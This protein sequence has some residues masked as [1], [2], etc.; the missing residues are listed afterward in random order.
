MKI[1]IRK[2]CVV[3]GTRAEYGLLKEILHKISLDSALQLQLVV[4]GTHLL[5]KFGNTIKTIE[6]DGFPIM[7]KIKSL[8]AGEDSLSI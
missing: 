2:V 6:K 4:T 3:T 5:K 7:A 8:Q 1:Y